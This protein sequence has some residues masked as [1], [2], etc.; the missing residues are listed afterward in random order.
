MSPPVLSLAIRLDAR[1]ETES[2][3]DYKS[4][5]IREAHEHGLFCPAGIIR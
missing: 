3:D 1:Q 2:T 5:I 4:E